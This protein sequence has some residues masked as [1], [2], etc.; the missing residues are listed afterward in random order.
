M[1]KSSNNGAALK[2][3]KEAN[4]QS[5]RNFETQLKE[6]RKAQKQAA[7]VQMPVYEQPAPGS[8]QSSQ[9]VQAAGMETRMQ[10]RRGYGYNWSVSANNPTLGSATAL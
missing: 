10:R 2:E 6:M 8:T 5:Q 7:D 3:Q 1:A 9:D 4:K